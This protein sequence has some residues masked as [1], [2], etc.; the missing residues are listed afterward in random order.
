MTP[1]SRPMSV[2]PRGQNYFC[3]GLIAVFRGSDADIAF[4]SKAAV[5][6]MPTW[7]RCAIRSGN[8]ASECP[9]LEDKP[10]SRAMCRLTAD[11]RDSQEQPFSK[12]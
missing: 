9:E 1:L 5:Q 8:A 11:S 12:F 10:T 6:R 2:V 4:G 7:F 3:F